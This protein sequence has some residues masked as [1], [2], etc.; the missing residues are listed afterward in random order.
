MNEVIFM[1]EKIKVM[2]VCS[3]KQKQKTKTL[4]ELIEIEAP[5]VYDFINVY[6]RE[7]VIEQVNK[8]RPKII[9]L[10]QNKSINAL[11]LV[12]KIK[13]MHP[14][15]VVFVILSDMLDDEQETID[16][17]MAAGAYKCYFS[18]LVLDTLVHDM[19][20]ALNLE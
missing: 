6:S 8:H 18:A 14:S 3:K 20:V 4:D 16:E 19:Y 10:S 11:E 9:F 5:D 2:F 15:I 17:Y 12:K 1:K 7:N 13:S